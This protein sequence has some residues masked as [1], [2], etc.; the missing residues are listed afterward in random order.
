MFKL[1]KIEKLIL[2]GRIIVFYGSIFLFI[3]LSILINLMLD[4]WII[5]ILISFFG[6]I[7]YYLLSSTYWIVNSIEKVDNGHELIEHGLFYGVIIKVYKSDQLN[8]LFL[9]NELRDKW[10]LVEKNL[11]DQPKEYYKNLKVED[12]ITISSDLRLIY[13]LTFI[14]LSVSFFGICYGLYEK[15]YEFIIFGVF[16]LFFA[17]FFYNLKKEES[18]MLV[19]DKEGIR[20]DDMSKFLW[21]KITDEKLK[22]LSNGIYLNFKNENEQV[23]IRLDIYDVK[24]FQLLNLIRYFKNYNYIKI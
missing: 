23:N 14:F 13:F 1:K 20:V 18:I 21:N 19:I 24:P 2:V 22:F 16:F 15:R 12:K 8:L 6:A 4:N 3:S 17:L 9:T 10:E 5:S 11:Q 7:I